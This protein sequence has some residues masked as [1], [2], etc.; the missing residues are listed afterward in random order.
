MK[1]T[2]SLVCCMFAA[3]SYL[4]P[5]A[6]AQGMSK[7]ACVEAHTNG[8]DARQKG[9][10]TLAKQLLMSCSQNDCPAIVRNDCAKLADELNQLQ[11]TVNFVARDSGGTDLPHTTVFVDGA[12]VLT[13]IDSGAPVEI[14]PGQH[15]IRFVNGSKEQTKTV[16]VQNGEKARTILAVFESAQSSPN[17][18]SAGPATAGPT[19][20]N[21]SVKRSFGSYL[22]LGAGL[23]AV[24]GGGVLTYMGI[25]DVPDGCSISD[26]TC[27]VAPGDES[28]TRRRTGLAK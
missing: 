10:L 15:T 1:L 16:V 12:L 20:V 17:V 22:L 27:N 19:D 2:V 5:R 9:K 3:T 21:G 13:R 18:T 14:D 7:D 23:A 25:A 8:Q 28:S 6:H 24:V 4:S 26:G 11:P